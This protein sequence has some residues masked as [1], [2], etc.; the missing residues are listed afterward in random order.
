MRV[1]G[2]RMDDRS[3]T[4]LNREKVRLFRKV[5]VRILGDRRGNGSDGRL[6]INEEDNHPHGKGV[7]VLSILK[8]YVNK[9]R[10]AE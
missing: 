4:R 10:M 5:N 2:K 3:Y 6:D 9:S 7:G 8:P 1:M